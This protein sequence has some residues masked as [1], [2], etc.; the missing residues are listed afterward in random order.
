MATGE[1][2]TGSKG[3]GIYQAQ[4]KMPNRTA[5]AA[6]ISGTEAS[7]PVLLEGYKIIGLLGAGGMGTVWRACQIATGRAVALK[8]LNSAWM[9]SEEAKRRFDREVKV[10]SRLEH[11]NIARV[12]DSGI[13]QDAYFYTM[14]LIEGLTLDDYVQRQHLAPRQ[15]VEVMSVVCRAIQ[16]AHE[17]GIVHRDLKPSN[18]IVDESHV[19]HLLDFGLGKFLWEQ[20]A[21]ITVSGQGQWVG[22]PAYM[23]PEQAD[24]RSN[25]VDERTDVYSLGVI[26]YQLVTGRL[27]HSTDGGNLAVLQRVVHDEIARPRRIQ[28]KI[29]RELEALIVKAT[30]KRRED[31]YSSACALADDIEKYLRGSPLDARHPSLV[32][33]LRKSVSRH[34]QPITFVSA[35]V[36]ILLCVV[37]Y[38]SNRIAGERKLAM[39]V[40]DEE[41][42]LHHLAQLR[43]A[44]SSTLLAG[45][46]TKRGQWRDAGEHLWDAYRIQLAEGAD[47]TAATWGLLQIERQAPAAISEFALAGSPPS[48]P[49]AVFC[50]AN[51]RMIRV[52]IPNGLVQTYNLLTGEF[53]GTVGRRIVDGQVIDA[54]LCPDARS[55]CQLVL[56]KDARQ[57]AT[58]EIDRMNLLDGTVESKQLRSGYANYP[59]SIASSGEQVIAGLIDYLPGAIGHSDVWLEQLAKDAGPKQ[60]AGHVAGRIQTISFASDLQTFATCDEQGQI[61]FYDLATRERSATPDGW[62]SSSDVQGLHSVQRMVLAPDGGGVLV[63]DAEGGVAYVSKTPTPPLR[64]FG[65]CDGPVRSLAFSNDGRLALSG[66]GSETITLWDVDAGRFRRAFYAGA[67]IVSM[68]FS[69]DSKLV[70][71]STADGVIHAWPVDLDEQPVLYRSR[72]KVGCIAVSPNGLIAAVGSASDVKL[73]DII[74]KEQIHSLHLDSTV[75]SLAFSADGLT[76]VASDVSGAISQFEVCGQ[77]ARL[78]HITATISSRGHP[79]NATHPNEEWSSAVYLSTESGLAID[80][81]SGG[82]AIMNLG[83]N[84]R[85]T[86]LDGVFDKIGCVSSHGRKAIG[87]RLGRERTLD[88]ISLETGSVVPIALE[89]SPVPRAVTFSADDGKAFVATDDGNLCAIDL[90]ARQLIWKVPSHQRGV[91]CLAAAPSGAAILSGAE[92]GTLRSFDPQDGNELGVAADDMNPISV[93]TFSKDGGMIFC[94]GGPDNSVCFWDLSLPERQRE[95]ESRFVTARRDLISG[96]SDKSAAADLIAWYEL[97]GEFNWGAILLSENNLD[98][99]VGLPAAQ[100]RWQAGDYAGAEADF[101]SLIRSTSKADFAKYLRACGDAAQSNAGLQ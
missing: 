20:P 75:S 92:D 99:Y 94:N 62:S 39:T 65:N 49:L 48:Y 98:A 45:S 15:V 93:I 27:P 68:R 71:A 4:G 28:P 34:H 31:R 58:Y 60:L 26:L 59:N 51:D 36:L 43:L 79:G 46:L 42:S 52:Q 17:K 90:A 5:I 69:A 8:L 81:T 33:L 41:Q 57:M 85:Q 77:W 61:R 91:L 83:A 16:Y 96:S 12:Y 72:Q 24:E 40:A 38:A 35:V 22:T 44:E 95:A 53:I 63:G 3:H 54:V 101:A 100:C 66:D 18:I 78:K 19:P 1:L 73:I 70:V 10:A 25:Q 50:D 55:V 37:L 84:S 9:F 74:T 13:H 97:R 47:T 86:D 67:R 7:T 30:A 11:V 76:L 88:L 89:H 64:R 32:Y 6:G 56:R 82:A 29:D 23:S 87:L 80:L 2:F 21:L 14:E